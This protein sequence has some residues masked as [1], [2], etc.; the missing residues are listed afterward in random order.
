MN[1]QDARHQLCFLSGENTWGAAPGSEATH[2][3]EMGFA[4]PRTGRRGPPSAVPPL[5]GCVPASPRR[6]P[7]SSSA[8]AA[9][10]FRPLPPPPSPSPP[11]K[12]PGSSANQNTNTPGPAEELLPPAPPRSRA[13][14]STPCAHFRCRPSQ[15]AARGPPTGRG[16]SHV[17]SAS[18]TAPPPPPPGR[19]IPVPRFPTPPLSE[20]TSLA[21]GCKAD[22][23][24][25]NEGEGCVTCLRP[26]PWPDL[27]TSLR[28]LRLPA[29][30]PPH[31]CHCYLVGRR[32]APAE[33]R[34]PDFGHVA[35]FR[36]GSA[37]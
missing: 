26:H 23:S 20:R 17:T 27:L 8:V 2:G 33:G 16:P 18:A 22:G 19:G 36:A 13:R 11:L 12:P 4:A 25:R 5:P 10:Q 15:Q 31:P 21:A 7:L 32:S 35:L 1:F 29:G 3:P 14:P 37:Q 34:R 28:G 30:S 6:L 24:V 9:L